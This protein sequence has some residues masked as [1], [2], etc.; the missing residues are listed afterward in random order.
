MRSRHTSKTSIL[1][2]SASSL[3][4]ALLLSLWGLVGGAG[5][6]SGQS[7]TL[8]GAVT[9]GY[10]HPHPLTGATV[11]L[12]RVTMLVQGPVDSTRLD[13][14]GQYRLHIASVDS[15]ATYLISVL[16]DGVGYFSEPIRPLRGG[17]GGGT[18][19]DT[20]RV[21]DTSVDGPPLSVSK[22]LV[23]VASPKQDGS[24]EVLEIA[25]LANPGE[26]TRIAADTLHPV[27]T[28]ALPAGVIQFSVGQGDFSADAV[29]RRGDSV[30]LF[31]AVQPGGGRQVSYS[32]LIPG[33]TSPVMLPVDH[34]LDNLMLL[35]EDTTARVTGPGLR[36]LGVRI[37]ETRHFAEYQ[38]DH[39]KA[40]ALVA[41]EFPRGRFR[42]ESL[43]PFIAV[44]AGVV[45][46]G[47]FWMALRRPRAP[48]S[49][50]S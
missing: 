38:I 27:W 37:L 30:A 24:R 32:Y 49:I 35:L 25:V 12:H 18:Q 44:L 15:T 1:K 19:V 11:T 5:V 33:G 3:P 13:A 43:V 39:V 4:N 7:V 2:I 29:A 16:H 41:I 40:G 26:T 47:G 34:P 31:G 8:T 45:L 9:L 14:R 48:A 22:R 50:A 21:Y 10:A 23:S 6:A 42:I 17:P 28:T 46:A 36:A 20:L